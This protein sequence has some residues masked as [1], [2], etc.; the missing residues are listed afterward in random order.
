M[1]HKTKNKE[2]I[3]RKLEAE[4]QLQGDFYQEKQIGDYWYIKMLYRTQYVCKWII[5]EY[6]QQSYDNY[7]NWKESKK[8]VEKR[9]QKEH[10]Q[11]ILN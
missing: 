11:S 2:R 9:E 3:A 7:K 10:L 4:K 6:S 1:S 5:C 8:M